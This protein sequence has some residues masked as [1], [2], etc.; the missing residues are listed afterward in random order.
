[1][2][3]AKEIHSFQTKSSPLW[4]LR[5]R[6]LNLPRKETVQK[7]HSPNVS[8]G[9][10]DWYDLNSTDL[11]S[12]LL[13]V[14]YAEQWGLDHSYLFALSKC[15]GDTSMLLAASENSLLQYQVMPPK[16]GQSQPEEKVHELQAGFPEGLMAYLFAQ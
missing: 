12:F 8:F 11:T 6:P 16:E 5:T 15:P 2:D 13:Q 3:I 10:L 9:L 4:K 7:T 1:M 14:L